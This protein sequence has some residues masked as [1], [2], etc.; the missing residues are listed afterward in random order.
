M[1][2]G[3]ASGVR[4]EYDGSP[5]PHGDGRN[6]VVG[7]GDGTGGRPCGDAIRQRGPEAQLDA[8]VVDGV[9]NGGEGETDLEDSPLSKAFS[10]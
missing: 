10:E 6:V 9:V 2:S 3:S 8:L 1:R 5:E 4:E 7:D